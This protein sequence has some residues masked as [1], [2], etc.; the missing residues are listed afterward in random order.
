MDETQLQS[1]IQD[2]PKPNHFAQQMREMIEQQ[3]PLIG[4]SQRAHHSAPINTAKADQV[5]RSFQ[6]EYLAQMETDAVNLEMCTKEIR[7]QIIRN[8]FSRSTQQRM[9]KG[10]DYAMRCTQWRKNIQQWVGG[11]IAEELLGQLLRLNDRM[12]AALSS[13]HAATT[14]FAEACSRSQE[15]QQK[16]S[17]RSGRREDQPPATQWFSP[18]GSSASRIL[19]ESPSSASTDSNTPREVS[20]RCTQ[21]AASAASPQLPS[22][23]AS[24]RRTS[25]IISSGERS[26]PIHASFGMPSQQQQPAFTAAQPLPLGDLLG[27]HSSSPVSAWPAS[28]DALQTRSSEQRSQA[29]LQQPAP[30]L[31]RS[32]EQ[33]PRSQRVSKAT[34]APA[35]ELPGKWEAQWP[36]VPGT[37]A[38]P[39]TPP[40]QDFWRSAE[41]S[42][43]ASPFDAAGPA[44]ARPILPQVSSATGF[45]PARSGA[46]QDFVQKDAGKDAEMAALRQQLEEERSGRLGLEHKLHACKAAEERLTADVCSLQRKLR[47]VRPLTRCHTSSPGIFELTG[48]ELEQYK[49]KGAQRIPTSDNNA[50]NSAPFSAYCRQ[51]ALRLRFSASEFQ[52]L[53][54]VLNKY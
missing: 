14:D 29:S 2:M 25:D 45:D 15:V 19:S 20:S 34:S 41:A 35:A 10:Q 13:W 11:N 36:A 53:A 28:Q 24:L 16:E 31:P 37:A 8:A 5:L 49:G 30:A 38:L 43:K 50:I 12:H 26:S 44:G 42:G 54:S 33:P 18:L 23:S 21:P 1:T 32:Q 46:A 47:R 51:P 3:I 9:S 7:S 6:V 52:A 22:A 48:E 27:F 39:A 4:A 17:P 40:A